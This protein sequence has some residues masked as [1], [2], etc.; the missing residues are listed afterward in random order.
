MYRAKEG[1][2]EG[3][4]FFTPAMNERARD[5]LELESALRRA[6]PGG[7]LR[8]HFQPVVEVESGRVIA[9]EALVRWEH[10]E[11]GLLAPDAFLEVAETTGLIAP[12]G[13]WVLREALLCSRGWQQDGHPETAVL[14]NLSARQFLEHDLVG[15]VRRVLDELG[16]SPALLELE[17]TE[18]LAMRDAAATEAALRG[19]KELGVRI[20]IDDFGT[21]YSSFH[22]LRR[23]PIDTL[24]IDRAFMRD[25]DRD[26]GNATIASAMIA[27]AH[28]LGLR[29][30]A[31]GVE[32]EEQLAFLR[33]QRCDAA[34]G[35]L[36][37]RPVPP[38]ELPRALRAARIP[39][40]ADAT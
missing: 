36:L 37:G 27:M 22:Y 33:E 24:K 2:S 35:F 15:E 30:I 40:P 12:M 14:V 13:S 16:A 18:S 1:G 7:Q 4:K 31:E 8:L 29:V 19:L 3:F 38:D 17:I 25:V 32:R 10:A 21:G 20:S 5:R 34:Q 9:C 26:P 23:F 39:Q 11:R 28:R 6:V